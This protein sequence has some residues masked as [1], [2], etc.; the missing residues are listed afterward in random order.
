MTSHVLTLLHNPKLRC[1]V[2]GFVERMLVTAI[3]ANVAQRYAGQLLE[4]PNWV[5]GCWG[6][7]TSST[8]N[9]FNECHDGSENE[10]MAL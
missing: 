9:D 7:K 8:M 4:L 5:T 10:A 6:G 2:A 3:D 1:A